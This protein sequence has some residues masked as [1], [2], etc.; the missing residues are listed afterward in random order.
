MPRHTIRTA[1]SHKRHRIATLVGE[2]VEDSARIS[3]ERE[4]IPDHPVGS[5]KIL[6]T[7]LFPTREPEHGF[8]DLNSTLGPGALRKDNA[9]WRKGFNYS[10]L[11]M[12]P[13]EITDYDSKNTAKTLAVKTARG[14]GDYKEALGSSRQYKGK[15]FDANG[16]PDQAPTSSQWHSIGGVAGGNHHVNGISTD[17]VLTGA[18]DAESH[19]R[20]AAR[21]MLNPTTGVMKNVDDPFAAH[22]ITES[23]YVF[24]VGR[25]TGQNAKDKQNNSLNNNGWTIDNK[26]EVSFSTNPISLGDGFGTQPAYAKNS[27]EDTWNGFT[28]DGVEKTLNQANWRNHVAGL[29]DEYAKVLLEGTNLNG[30]NFGTDLVRNPKWNP[31]TSRVQGVGGGQGT[32]DTGVISSYTSNI[33]CAGT[34]VCVAQGTDTATASAAAGGSGGNIGEF[35]DGVLKFGCNH[36]G[37]N[38]FWAGN[39]GTNLADTGNFGGI[40]LPWY[41]KSIGTMSNGKECMIGVKY[42]GHKNL[43]G[44]ANG[45]IAQYT[46]YQVGGAQNPVDNVSFEQTKKD[47]YTETIHSWENAFGCLDGGTIGEKHITKIHPKLE[48]TSAVSTAIKF[49]RRAPMENTGKDVAMLGE[50]NGRDFLS[51][52]WVE[53][54]PHGELSQVIIIPEITDAAGDA[55]SHGDVIDQ[56]TPTDQS[57]DIALGPSDAQRDRE[58][59]KKHSLIGEDFTL[60]THSAGDLYHPSALVVA[61]FVRDTAEVFED[62]HITELYPNANNMSAKSTWMRNYDIVFKISIDQTEDS[63]GPLFLKD[64]GINGS[65]GQTFTFSLSSCPYKI[66]EISDRKTTAAGKH[67]WEIQAMPAW[68]IV[69]ETNTQRQILFKTASGSSTKIALA[70]KDKVFQNTFC[71]AGSGSLTVVNGYSIDIVIANSVADNKGAAWQIGNIID[72]DNFELGTVQEERDL[73][74]LNT[75]LNRHLVSGTTPVQYEFKYAADTNQS[76]ISVN[77]PKLA[78]DNKVN[79]DVGWLTINAGASPV[80]VSDKIVDLVGNNSTPALV[81]EPSLLVLKADTQWYNSW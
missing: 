38:V 65:Y 13:L 72:I 9:N 41:H 52:A 66:R 4:L 26:Y 48:V 35:T 70:A 79:L 43:N 55:M 36:S 54:K 1:N 63:T 21:F 44:M 11:T 14:I 17:T 51:H 23:Q 30:M 8:F 80:I 15:T 45:F 25:Y 24:Q 18:N 37:N 34:G 53:Y 31:L 39:D 62:M 74:H 28:I 29:G 60:F 22:D 42:I 2:S 6:D 46:G 67:E 59:A 19:L 56:G 50:N 75:V 27:T 10:A 47:Y 32:V 61:Q 49:N 7:K 78:T 68:H 73:W 81:F 76:E 12:Y 57:P 77:I 64:D 20:T 58:F 3:N 71:E 40:F 69:D 5:L 33:L 16:N